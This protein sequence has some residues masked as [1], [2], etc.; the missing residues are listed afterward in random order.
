MWLGPSLQRRSK[1]FLQATTK[2]PVLRACLAASCTFSELRQHTHHSESCV[3]D[4]CKEGRRTELGLPASSWVSRS[5]PSTHVSAESAQLAPN[6]KAEPPECKHPGIAVT[7]SAYRFC[8]TGKAFG[9]AHASGKVP[10][11]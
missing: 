2:G 8:S 3:P 11:E 6:C 1:R 4:F 9:D 10:A 7:E 5:A